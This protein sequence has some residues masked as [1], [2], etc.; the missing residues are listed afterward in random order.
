MPNKT[1]KNT[2]ASERIKCVKCGK[3]DAT[4][5]NKMC[6]SCRFTIAIENIIES[7]A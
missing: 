6:D 4:G 2:T 7:R 5:Q 3:R 1:L